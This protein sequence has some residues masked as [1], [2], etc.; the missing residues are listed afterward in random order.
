MDERLRYLPDLAR[1]RLVWIDWHGSALTANRGS[2][3]RRP[4]P[5]HSWL[6]GPAAPPTGSDLGRGTAWMW[7]DLV[8]LGR[9]AATEIPRHAIRV[10]ADHEQL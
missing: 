3:S 6:S 8:V 10:G 9:I 4:A 7:Q 2:G 1:R 5:S